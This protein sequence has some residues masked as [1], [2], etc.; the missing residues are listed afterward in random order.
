MTSTAQNIR[1]IVNIEI[2]NL[3]SSG[4]CDGFLS[5]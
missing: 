4:L 3:R 2:A 1:N 5:M